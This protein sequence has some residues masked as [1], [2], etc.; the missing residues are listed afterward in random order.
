MHEKN[1]EPH[2]RYMNRALQRRGCASKNR[3]KEKVIKNHK[4]Q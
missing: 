1:K 3:E 4:K 2:V